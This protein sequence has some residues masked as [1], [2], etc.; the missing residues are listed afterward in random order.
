MTD[1]ASST[2][3]ATADPQ[4]VAERVESAL[5]ECRARIDKLIVQLDSA[6]MD[7]RDELYKRLNAVGNAGL[8]ARSELGYARHDLVSRLP[9]QRDTV[10]AVLHD[11][12]RAVHGAREAF[13]RR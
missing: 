1:A 9:V 10:S 3:G 5:I 12:Q 6:N 7:L 11:L 2:E 13:D 8:A 4:D